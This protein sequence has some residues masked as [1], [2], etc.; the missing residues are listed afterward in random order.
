MQGMP[1]LVHVAARDSGLKS[2]EFPKG[3][4]IR[5]REVINSSGGNVFGGSYQ[6]VIPA[7]MTDRKGSTSPKRKQFKLKAKAESWARDQ[8]NASKRQGPD[9]FRASDS[10]RRL[11]IECLPKVRQLKGGLL[12]A[13][14]L[15]L[16][17]EGEGLEPDKAV[18]FAVRHLKPSGGVK[19]L[20]QV[21]EELRQSKELR[22][23]R[24]D[25]RKSSY[26]D[27]KQ[28]GAK[29]CDALG[30]VAINELS[31]DDFKKWLLGLGGSPRTTKNYLSVA[32]EIMRHAHE[33][34]YVV[35]S[36]LDKL[37]RVERKDLIGTGDSKEPSILT[38]DE[39]ERLLTAAREHEDLK[40]LPAVTL[41][42]FCGIRTEEL[43]RL[44]WR[45]VKL[46]ETQ[47]VVTISGAIA[48]KRRIRHVEIPENALKWLSLCGNKEG[49]ITYSEINDDYQKRFRRLLKETGFLKQD[50]EGRWRSSWDANSMRHSFG[51]YHFALHGNS[52]ETSRLLGHRASDQVL[53]DHY[54]ALATKEQAERYFALVP[55]VSSTNLLSFA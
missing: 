29:L 7:E 4:G 14:D 9:Y 34:G 6:V 23:G 36:P 39:A 32:S 49:R 55:S 31:K 33:S 22:Y 35:E 46:E 44:D 3:S 25:L 26:D 50:E 19:T 15:L 48:K 13:V 2:W 40:L 37:S 38:V 5:I 24:G 54:R 43:K 28:R 41:G 20:A 10:E 8:W 12:K 11:F 16:R 42:L 51:S 45:D 17:L 27:F 52:L 30:S 18:E 47:P 21:V 1:F 53:F